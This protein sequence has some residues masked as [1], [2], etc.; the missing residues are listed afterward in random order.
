MTS[1][2]FA[3]ALRVTQT[4]TEAIVWQHLRAHRLGDAK[5]KRQQPL[6]KYIVDFVCFERRLIVELDGGQHSGSA[7]DV[8]RD[9]WLREQ[10]FVVE[11][12]WNN[13]VRQ[14]LPGVLTRILEKLTEQ[15]LVDQAPSPSIPPPPRGREASPPSD[16]RLKPSRSK[17]SLSS[18]EKVADQ[19]PPRTSSLS[20][21]EEDSDQ[22]SPHRTSSRP[23]QARVSDQLPRRTSLLSTQERDSDQPSPPRTS[24]LPPRGGGIEG[25]GQFP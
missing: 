9:A 18:Q 14:N 16:Y 4:D 11:R 12:F 21:Q 24:S 6:G 22:Q 17:G 7:S 5:F 19:S 8:V 23:L 25:E 15:A 1:I 3:K 10:G 13:D 20:T 2:D